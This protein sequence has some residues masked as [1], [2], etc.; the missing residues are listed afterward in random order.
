MPRATRRRLTRT[1]Q[2]AR[3]RHPV[4][5]A[6]VGAIVGIAVQTGMPDHTAYAITKTF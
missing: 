5:R 3:N 2:R 6:T 4:R 1:V